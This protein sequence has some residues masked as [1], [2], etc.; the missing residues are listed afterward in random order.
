MTKDDVLLGIES[1][2]SVYPTNI[3]FEDEF[4]SNL[5][6]E[7]LIDLQ[8]KAFFKGIY[9]LIRKEKFFP[10]PALI[11][12]YAEPHREEEPFLP[13]VEN[14][15]PARTSENLLEARRRLTSIARALEAGDHAS[16]RKKSIHDPES[17]F[18]KY[19][20]ANDDPLTDFG[21]YFGR[22]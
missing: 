1:L 22:A 16:M 5:W 21:T 12:Q 20:P 7:G 18:V 17:C 9:E 13:P 19:R 11:R 2:C 15:T 4:V 8:P 3:D 6:V 14:K 10:S